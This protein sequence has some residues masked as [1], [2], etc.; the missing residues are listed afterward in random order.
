M[1]TKERQKDIMFLDE[2]ANLK[3]YDETARTANWKDAEKNFS[4]FTTGKVNMV[5]EAI[6][7]EPIR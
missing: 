7:N 3:N 4:W 1:A 6:Y 5:Y 2:T